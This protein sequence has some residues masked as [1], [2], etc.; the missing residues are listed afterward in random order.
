VN[1]GV[2][3]ESLR[4]TALRNNRV[5]E[6]TDVDYTRERISE[7]LQPHAL[8][9]RRTWEPTPCYVDHIPFCNKGIGAIRFG[10]MQVQVPEIAD[11]Y[12]FIMC[13]SGH[14]DMTVGHA[15]YR[16]D[17]KRGLLLSPGEQMLATFSRDCEQLFVRIDKQAIAE[18]SSFRKLQFRHEVD[19][20]N[21]RLVPW[22]HHVSTIIS[23]RHTTDFLRTMPGI[24]KEYE[25]L[26][27]SFLLAGQDHCDAAE[28][29]PGIAP[30]SVRR[31]E[32]FINAMHPEAITLADIATAA[33]VPVRTLL[34]SFRRFRNTSPI[35][36][37]RDVRLDRARE[38]LQSGKVST[39]AEAAMNVGMTHL[40]RFAGEYAERFGEKPSDTLRM[41][42]ARA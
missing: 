34:E 39:A 28:Q 41:S 29:T 7:I 8:Q 24:A 13:L 2:L 33:D 25:R 36:Y 37:L 26:L 19:L 22:L 3:T 9:P 35:R 12:L 31:A 4:P 15:D 6:S 21:P 11:Y 1:L 17:R 40:G 20:H 30:G 5:F 18:H 27:L 14:A 16:I 42:R 38:A 10:E 32:Q 23:D